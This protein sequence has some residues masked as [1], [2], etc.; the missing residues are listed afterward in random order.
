M[1]K[2]MDMAMQMSKGGKPDISNDKAKQ[3]LKE[4]IGNNFEWKIG[5]ID[6][7]LK[8]NIKIVG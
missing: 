2:Y 3:I 1:S 8:R 6:R 5:D 4:M 7:T